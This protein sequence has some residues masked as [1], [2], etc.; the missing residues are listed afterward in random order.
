MRSET[1]VSD[2]IAYEISILEKD[3]GFV[4]RWKCSACGR[5]GG[6]PYACPTTAEA[7][8]RAEADLLAEHH[9]SAHW[10]GA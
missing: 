8:G 3:G 5:E 2:G 9:A 6:L 7:L 4:A 10:Q 1:F